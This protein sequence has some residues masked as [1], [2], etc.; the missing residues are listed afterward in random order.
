[1]ERR[2]ANCVF[3]DDLREEVGSK[4]S[5]MGM[6][7]SELEIP[8]A[9]PVTLPKL[10]IAAWLICDVGDLP[11]NVRYRVLAPPDGM[12]LFRL[13]TT[14]GSE[15]HNSPGATQATLFTAIPISPITLS[16]GG[17][18]E[19]MIDTERETMRAGRILVRFTPSD[20]SSLAEILDER[21]A[22]VQRKRRRA[23]R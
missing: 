13:D 10:I 1:M 6:Y 22:S 8:E 23:K 17:Y 3:C 19:V 18:L 15:V 2:V 7:F 12:E 4:I 5:L 21:P 11:E 14:R 9:P 20:R 16:G